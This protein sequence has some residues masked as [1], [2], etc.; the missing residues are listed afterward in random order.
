MDTDCPE[1]KTRAVQG[2]GG[3]GVRV[4]CWGRGGV[5]VRVVLGESVGVGWCWCQ[6]SVLGSG[7]VES[8]LN[9][10]WCWGQS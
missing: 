10:R 4:L 5:E 1:V 8:V 3:V 9:S 6:G 2:W 7:G